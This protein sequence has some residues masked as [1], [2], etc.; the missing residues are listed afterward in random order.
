MTANCL[1]NASPSIS[2]PASG[3]P[4]KGLRE[5]VCFLVLSLLLCLALFG[6]AMSGRKLLAPLDVAPNL[7]SKFK[8][9]NPQA[10]GI[11]ANHYVI[12]QVVGDLPRN[13]L[14]YQ[15]WH[16]GEM[17]WWDPYT[18]GGK[19]LAAEANAI[20]ISDP[21]KVLFYFTLPFEL[22]YNWAR[23][24]TFLVSGL[25]AFL[26]LRRFQFSFA[27]AVWGALLF[28]FAG[29]NAIMFSGPTI[30]ASCSYIPF[31]W[32]LWDKAMVEKRLQWFLIS[33]L[34]SAL[35]FLSGNLQSHTYPF[36]FALAFVLGYGWRQPRSWPLLL[37]G[38]SLSFALG[39]GLAAPFV[40]PEIELFFLST[41]KL[42]STVTPLGPLSGPLSLS[43]IFP[44]ALGTFR[45]LDASK[46]TGQ[47]ALG[48]WAFIGSAALLIAIFGATAKQG[49]GTCESFRK[50]T[51]LVLVLGYFF[52]CSTPLVRIF[53]TRTAWLA[54]LGLAVLFAIG[55]ERLKTIEIPARKWGWTILA[56]AIVIAASVNVAGGIIYPRFQAKVEAYVL[57]KQATNI[58][59]DEATELRK[60]QVANLPRE[61]TFH[62]P[63]TLLSFLSMLG[64][65]LFLLRPPRSHRMEWLTGIVMLSTLPLLLFIHRYIPQQPVALWHSLRAGGPEQHRVA[66]ALQPNALR[67]AEV[68]PGP[69][70]H[71]FPGALAQLFAVHTLQGHTSLAPPNAGQV[72]LPNGQP[73]PAYYDV[74]CQSPVREL[75]RGEILLRTNGPPARFHWDQPASRMVHIVGETLNTITLN[76]GPGPAAELIRTDTWYPGWHIAAG[77]P[78]VS[79]APKPPFSAVLHI[80]AGPHQVQ[81]AYQPRPWRVGIWIAAV[82]LILLNLCLAWLF[83]R[84]RKA[85]IAAVL[86]VQPN[87]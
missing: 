45:T 64:V 4:R 46:I 14:V 86:R 65:G 38:I 87:A 62:N 55:W 78:D 36:F 56:L 12:D 1:S 34:I 58:T 11:P 39:F 52:I 20:N 82:A 26:L 59:L 69:H 9:M 27:T 16:R 60:Y 83:R 24:F 66:Q 19:P 81:L 50:R 28:Q 22:A 43:A 3:L 51:A 49:P 6:P 44:W 18:D 17:P 13:W 57:K 53:Y 42:L 37:G 68:A 47:Y 33:S 32:L 23:I 25:G 31:L 63:E 35:I 70:E 61:V 79:L 74:L 15:A 7:F 8:Y 2:A 5:A 73:D 41:R 30:Q 21:W 85:R 71:V 84:D 72:R 75:E 40:L 67:L 76:I 80:P 77:S 54:V 10:A 48:F 29:G